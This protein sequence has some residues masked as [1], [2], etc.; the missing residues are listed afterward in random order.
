MGLIFIKDKPG[1]ETGLVVLLSGF[2]L[3]PIVCLITFIVSSIVRWSWVLK[4]KM[5]AISFLVLLLVWLF[6]ILYYLKSLLSGT[7][8]DC[9]P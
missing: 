9:L 5:A 4:N 3:A 7:I 8:L 2:Y 1:E 6:A